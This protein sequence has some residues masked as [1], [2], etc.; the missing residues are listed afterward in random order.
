MVLCVGS[1]GVG[2]TTI[3]AAL[4]L[5]A[6]Q[7]GQRVLCLTIDPAKRL[8]N[9]LGLD[10]MTGE[11]TRVDDALFRAAGVEVSGSLTVMMLDT[12]RT[13]DELVVR[14]AS[15]PEARDRILNNRL[16]QYV[17]TSLAGTQEYM[18]MEKLLSVKRDTAYDLIILDTPPTSNALDFLDAPN[19]LINALDSA[20]MR[21]F[22][23]AFESGGKFSL[24][25]VARS[26]AVVLRGIGR[27]TG[28]GFLEQMAEF[29][30]DL[31]D[32][33]GGFRERATE[34]AKA[35]RGD[36]FAYVIVTTPAPA[37]I[38]EAVFFAERLEEQD[39]RRDAFVVNRVHRRPRSSASLEQVKSA[40][41]RHHLELDAGGSERLLRALEE[42]SALAE[43]DATHVSEL[44]QVI[45]GA[46]PHPVRIDIPALPSDVHDIETLAGISALLCPP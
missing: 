36:E 11:A 4:G 31:N 38:R 17:S 8:A 22:I 20:A 1:G 14:H 41:E 21:W 13:F 10:R 2:K 39:M 42:E 26:V 12:K 15:S 44:E 30:T 27:L 43:L 24:N 9:S 3:T 33:F 32:L 37:S 40:V 18:A 28:G 25:L 45:V 5:A 23:Q 16:Y 7:R 46:D 35:F 6:A 19:R 34:V 29:I